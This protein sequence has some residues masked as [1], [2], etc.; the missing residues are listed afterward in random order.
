MGAAIEEEEEKKEED[1]F[2]CRS[3]FMDEPENSVIILTPGSSIHILSC[4]CI[5]PLTPHSLGSFVV[6]SL[7][8]L[9]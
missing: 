1:A 2:F 3:G 9:D 6:F 5:Q 4:T 7:Q 8:M